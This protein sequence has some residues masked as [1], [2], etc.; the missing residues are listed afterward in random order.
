MRCWRRRRLPVNCA[1]S[2]EVDGRV[3]RADARLSA[4]A[5]V[6]ARNRRAVGRPA[7]R[8]SVAEADPL[9]P[10]YRAA[11]AWHRRSPFEPGVT[12]F[13]RMNG[14]EI[15]EVAVGPVHAGIIEPGHFR[16]QCHGEDVSSSGNFARLPAS[17]RRARAGRRPGQADH[18]LHGNAGRR[19]D[20]RP[21]DG[22]TARR[23]RR[24]R[25]A[26]CR[27]GRRRCAASRWNWSGWPITPATSARWP[28]DVGY[29]PTAS[30]LRPHPRRFP[31]HDRAALRQPV[32]PR[33][34][35]ARRRGVRPRRRAA[36]RNFGERL[37]AGAR[38]T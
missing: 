10:F 14:D 13:F 33:P 22:A 9:S 27:R 24:W 26:T 23:S 3:S 11:D 28:S 19:H 21:R 38:A 4:G 12:D 1:V 36:R 32:R 25:A 29:L 35:A 30:L 37:A 18:P 34:G 31:E 2:T 5:L 20:H 6:R 8:A 17:R 16:F 15:H 7:G